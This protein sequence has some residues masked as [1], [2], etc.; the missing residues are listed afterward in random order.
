MEGEF[1]ALY[2]REEVEAALSLITMFY[3]A[4]A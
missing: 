1:V 2:T 3:S 4:N